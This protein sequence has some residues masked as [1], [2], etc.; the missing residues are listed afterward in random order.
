VVLLAQLLALLLVQRLLLLAASL[1]SFSAFSRAKYSS[2]VSVVFAMRRASQMARFTIASK[3][4]LGAWP[5]IWSATWPFLKRSRVG[6][7][8]TLYFCGTF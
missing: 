3:I 5:T 4:D 8:I 7:L 6:M 1:R 2:S